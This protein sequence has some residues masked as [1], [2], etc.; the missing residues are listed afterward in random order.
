MICKGCG[1]SWDGKG[2]WKSL[3]T[4]HDTCYV[5]CP[6]CN[7]GYTDHSKPI[8]NIAERYKQMKEEQKNG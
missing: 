1:I 3:I 7:K 8:Q 4:P 6:H 5:L 2:Y